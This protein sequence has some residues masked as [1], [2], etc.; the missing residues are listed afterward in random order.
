MTYAFKNPITQTIADFLTK[1]GLEVRSTKITDEMFLS[2]IRVEH[3]VL[4]V[5]EEKLTYPGD[6]LHEA[7]HLAVAPAELRPTLSGEVIIPGVHMEPVEAQAIA[8]S[9]AA[10]VHLGLDPK[11]IFHAGGYRVESERVEFSFSMGVYIGVNGLQAAGLTVMG[12]EAAAQGL[13]QYP[14]MIKWLRD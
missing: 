4:L 9:Y 8:W 11:V 2:G 7:G 13:P 6:V 14:H 12:P 1:I 10:I 5:D 3:G